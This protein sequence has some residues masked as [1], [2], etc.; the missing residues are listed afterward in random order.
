ME[1]RIVETRGAFAAARRAAAESASACVATLHG[2]VAP[3]LHAAHVTTNKLWQLRV[4][5]ALAGVEAALEQYGGTAWPKVR[6]W[7]AGALTA[8]HS[9]A[10]RGAAAAAA[11][12]LKAE[13]AAERRGM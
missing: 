7:V 6:G 11:R 4:K 13:A 3:V 10:Q 12:G 2:A 9:A 8:V 5:P 1:E